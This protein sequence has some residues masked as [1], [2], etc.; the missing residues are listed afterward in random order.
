[1]LKVELGQMVNRIRNMREELHKQLLARETPGDWSCLLKQTGMFAYS[2][3]SLAQVEH[4]TKK[5]HIY[6]PKSGRFSMA[7][8]SVNSCSYLADAVDDAVRNV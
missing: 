5:W 1:M 6:L 7:G 2:G 3:L 8:L 4:L